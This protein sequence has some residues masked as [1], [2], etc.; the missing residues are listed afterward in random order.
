MLI[1]PPNGDQAARPV[2]SYRTIRTL[3]AP[4]GALASVNGSQSGFESRTSSLMTPL[5]GFLGMSGLPPDVSEKVAVS[6]R[7]RAGGKWTFGPGESG[8]I[9]M[10]TDH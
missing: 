3:G 2:S 4:S 1:P 8:V 5:K 9:A 7:T 6:E 10:P